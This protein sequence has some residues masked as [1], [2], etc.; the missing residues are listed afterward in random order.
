MRC[1]R[2]GLAS[3]RARRRPD[4]LVL[5][6][7]CHGADVAVVAERPDGPARRRRR[8]HRRAGPRPGRPRRRLHPGPALGR[9]GRRRRSRPRRP[10]RDDHRRRR[11]S[12][13][14]AMRDLGATRI[15]AVVGPSVCGR[16]YEVPLADARGRRPSVSPESQRRVTGPGTPAIDVAAGVV[17]QL[18]AAGVDDLTWVPGCAREDAVAL[19]LPSRRHDRSVRRRHRP[20][21]V[22]SDAPRRARGRPARRSASASRAAAA[23][24]GR[25]ADE[26]ELVVV[27]KYFPASDVDLL[28]DLGVRHIGENKD[29]EAARQGRRARAA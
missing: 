27:T 21:S 5:M 22:V 23:A 28:V 1:G 4:R 12:A 9:G 16:C 18:R 20:G 15:A 6:D 11:R 8:R 17:A 14:S 2:T 24:A 7:Q 25:A 3:R 26:I 29:Q 19:L 13:V 10:A